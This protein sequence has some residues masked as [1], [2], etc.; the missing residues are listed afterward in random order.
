MTASEALPASK[1]EDVLEELGDK[2]PR[3]PAEAQAVIG[4]I[5]EE[6]GHLDPDVLQEL[7]SM[8]PKFRR[9]FLRMMHQKRE[10]EAA[11]TMRFDT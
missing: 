4:K 11:Y 8:T 3:K 10:T 7:D 2:E 5:R 6:K 9:L 1:Y